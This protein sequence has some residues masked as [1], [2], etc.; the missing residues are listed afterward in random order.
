MEVGNAAAGNTYA[1][2]ADVVCD[3]ARNVGSRPPRTTCIV[4]KEQLGRYR[5][6]GFVLMRGVLDEALVEKMARAGRAIADR[7]A[8]YPQYFSVVE[9]GPIFDGG[10]A[11][12]T[13]SSPPS[14]TNGDEL[15]Y[16]HHPDPLDGMDAAAVF[17]QAA[18]YS[19]IPQ[20]AAELMELDPE[21][22]NLRV[23]R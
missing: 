10:A 8:R 2:K 18:I 12:P 9:N 23:L 15:R 21:R 1:S 4:D 13:S 3:K 16:Q 5:Q 11:T 6:D 20:I 22:Q 7:A 19:T 17:R 14:A